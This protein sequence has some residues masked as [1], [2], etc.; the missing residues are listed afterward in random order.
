M[1]LALLTVLGLANYIEREYCH[2][3]CLGDNMSLSLVC[4]RV[5]IRVQLNQLTAVDVLSRQNNSS[6]NSSANSECG[7]RIATPSIA[8]DSAFFK[9]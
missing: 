8:L 9:E 4:L 2:K 3:S 5:Q 1:R 7:L 6:P